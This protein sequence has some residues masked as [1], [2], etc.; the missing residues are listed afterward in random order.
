MKNHKKVYI[1]FALLNVISIYLIS[2]CYKLGFFTSAVFLT[3]MFL[4]QLCVYLV[5]FKFL[6][7]GAKFIYE[8]IKNQIEKWKEAFKKAED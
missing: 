5:W 3:T 6:R 4:I 8:K 7:K 1:E 2:G